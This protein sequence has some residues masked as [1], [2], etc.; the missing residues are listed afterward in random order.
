MKDKKKPDG[1]TRFIEKKNPRFKRLVN[2]AMDVL[3][4]FKEM[5]SFPTSGL[6]SPR[7][8]QHIRVKTLMSICDRLITLARA[9]D[10]E[11][12]ICG[13]IT[14]SEIL[15][16]AFGL[17]WVLEDNPEN[18]GHMPRLINAKPSTQNVSQSNAKK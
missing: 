15:R 3:A 1:L 2:R 9:C 5:D 17:K 16:V 13:D 7:E 4:W 18:D 11:E 6:T 8:K 12:F 10:P 14:A